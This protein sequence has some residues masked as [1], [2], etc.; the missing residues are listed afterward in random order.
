MKYFRL[1]FSFVTGACLAVSCLVSATAQAQ[2]VCLP[3]P[4][5][6]TTMPM[7]GQAGTTFE[8]T[9][10]GE[11][12]ED[13][14]ELSFSHEGI[15]ATPSLGKDGLPVP[16][17]YT[18]T[19]SKD[20]P[21]GIHEARVMTRL[22]VSSS[23]AFNVG[24]LPETSQAAA[25]TTLETAKKLE[26]N[27][28]CNAVMSRQ[29]IDYY[30]FEAGKD[31]RVIVDCAAKGIDSKLNPV[32]IIADERGMD[33]VVERRGGMLD[34]NVPDTG[35]YIIKV[36]GLTYDGG[37][38]H[39]YRLAV[40]NVARDEIVPRMP[41]IKKV[42]AFSWPP[43]GLTNETLKPESEPNNTHAEA[44]KITLPCDISGSFFPAADVDTFEFTAKKGEVWWV[45]VASERLG[46][47]TDPSIVVQHVSGSGS[48]VKITDLVEL[49]DI[50]SPVRVSSN[51]YSYNGPPYNAG[52]SDILGKV[53]I[54]QDG[55]HHLQIRDLFGGTRND[56][57]NIYRL[58]IRKAAPDYALVGWAL[59]MN[60]R[61][62][63]RNALSKPI[64]LRG[65]ATMPL[66]VVVVRR[67]GFDGEIEL[68]MENLPEG[69]SATGLKIG[70]G[71]SSGTM[72]ISAAEG[73]PRG[74]T[75]AKFFG[76][77]TIADQI[78]TRPCYLASMQWPV[79]NAWSEVPSPR[80]MADVPVSVGI[81]EQAPITIAPA[82]EK[83]W[84]VTAGEKLTIPLK[85][86]R[87]SEFSGANIT[88]KTYGEGFNRNKAFDAPLKADASEVVLDLATLK[89]PPGEYQ[90][91]FGGY[92]VVK[93]S[94]NPKA[95]ALAEA[96]LK[97]AQQQAEALV[98]DAE[99]LQKKGDAAAKEA[100][101]KAKTAQAAVAKAD[102]QLKQATAKA[103]P[104]DIVDIIFSK[105]INI[106]VN[107]A[108]KAK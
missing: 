96:E 17:K 33:L 11:N 32:V 73:A 28:I 85:H 26:L 37:P 62:G 2:L 107:P 76:R 90:I 7:G 31:Q 104:K 15:T 72:L 101:A 46:R 68:F 92:A 103:K 9:I 60:L 56:A 12:I 25:N 14:D 24:R 100:A 88:L 48:E 6:L 97:E 20:C 47:P 94:E 40:K 29:K 10:S 102:K 74:L 78:V 66:E 71:K 16:N 70:K 106:R 34:F 52:S 30:T 81:S 21:L 98:A 108:K 89:T 95:V 44:Q 75:S 23:R 38:Y 69:V 43:A 27:S 86:V 67:D 53:E 8:V 93:Y 80:L 79:K 35:K 54:K 63:D 65:G 61:N 36:H 91:A 77:A 13:A 58:I 42:S 22:G 45:E 64:A 49:S 51:G 41:S 99:Q 84:E 39:F 5:L 55:V 82:E 105:P 1:Q 4:R 18:I 87:R 19:I 57:K 3:A 83:T 50:P 59:H